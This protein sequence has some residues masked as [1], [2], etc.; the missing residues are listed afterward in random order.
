MRNSFLALEEDSAGRRIEYSGQVPSCDFMVRQ[1]GTNVDSNKKLNFA[2][3][4][5]KPRYNRGFVKMSGEWTVVSGKRN[6]RIN[7]QKRAKA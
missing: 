1:D 7:V 5:K 6:E 4:C 3:Q 2:V